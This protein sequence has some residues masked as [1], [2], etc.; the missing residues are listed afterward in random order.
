[1]PMPRTHPAID[2]RAVL[3]R[4][5]FLPQAT[6]HV[7]ALLLQN[8]IS[9]EGLVEEPWLVEVRNRGGLRVKE[10]IIHEE[11]VDAST[12]L[13]LSSEVGQMT[14]SLS[15]L[16]AMLLV[17]ASFDDR[18]LARWAEG[19]ASRGDSLFGED[20]SH[21][22]VLAKTYLSDIR[23][24]R[25]ESGKPVWAIPVAD[26]IELCPRISGDYWRLPNRP[27]ER[28]WVHMDPTGD[29]SS[30][31]RV[32]RLLKERIRRDLLARCA[33]RMDRMDDRFAG[34]L[35]EQAGEVVGVLQAQAAHRV[36]LSGAEPEDWPPC[37]AN[38][39]LELASGVNVNHVGRVFLAAMSSAIGLERSQC[40]G[41]FAGAPD[42]DPD[43]TRYQVDH[44][45]DGGYTPH[46]CQTLKINARCPV[47]PGEDSLCDQEWM[48]HPLKYL[49]VKQRRHR[50][51]PPDDAVDSGVEQEVGASNTANP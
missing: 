2:D 12:V 23:I 39:V 46:G 48:T 9:I 19:E 44:V 38:A 37:M 22:E 33:E 15:F 24:V 7:R 50:D 29:E 13:D 10:S 18:L 6:E 17:C 42:Y 36:E 45:Y 49:R 16:Y 26:F 31:Q 41:F 1:M 25:Q 11:G 35:A 27:V 34:L 40:T 32:S 51:A 8:D 20:D 5:P 21:F 28:G 43:T 30:Q 3:S 47:A 14:E 4:Y